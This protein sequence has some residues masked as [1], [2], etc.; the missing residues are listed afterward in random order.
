M[1]IEGQQKTIVGS[2][3]V[4]IGQERWRLGINYSI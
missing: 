3:V 1:M 2:A 4:K